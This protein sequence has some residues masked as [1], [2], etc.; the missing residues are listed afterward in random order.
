VTGTE[1][2]LALIRQEGRCFLQRRPLT[3][4]VFPGL[5]ELPG[6]KLEPG[7]SPRAALERELR[8]ELG[9]RAEQVEALPTVVHGYADFEV[10]LHPFRCAGADA[11]RTSLA[12][13]WF[14]P[15]EAGKLQVPEGTRRLLAQVM[16]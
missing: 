16:E 9:W 15:A 14:L 12:W 6:G 10:V 7:E 11:P 4:S 3:A 5:W 1:V 13:G 2:A 8:E